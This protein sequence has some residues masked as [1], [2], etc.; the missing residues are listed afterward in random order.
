MTTGYQ[1]KQQDQLYFLTFQVV[2][3]VDVFS[4]KVYRDIVID[5]LAFCQKNKGL[6]VF[7]FVIMSNHMHLLARSATNELSKTIK[8]FKSF[9]A[10]QILNEIENGSESRKEWMLDVFKKAAYTHQRNSHYQFWTHENHAEHIFSNKFIEQK[11][12][13]IHQNPVRAGIVNN[14]N[15]YVY[16]SAV[17]YSGGK[18]ILDVELIIL[19][20]KTI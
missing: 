17:N 2:N 7:G 20:W 8:E 19:R 11:L 6:E 1:I 14:E 10:K 13:Y 3:W 9:T 5:N 16:S 12:I 18:G 15:D 4:R